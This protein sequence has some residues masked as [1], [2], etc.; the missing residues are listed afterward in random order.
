MLRYPPVTDVSTDL[1]DRPVLV[2]AATAS[3]A[4]PAMLESVDAAF[5]NARTRRYQLDAQT[6]FGLVAD[7]VKA[8]GWDIVQTRQPPEALSEGQ[9]NAVVTTLAGWRDEVAIRVR[10]DV[11]GTV[12]DMRSA[13][14]SGHHHDLG[15]NGLRIEEFLVALDNEVI[16][17]MRDTPQPA[18]ADEANPDDAPETDAPASGG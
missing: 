2:S 12:V 16:L 4:A 17:L 11:E 8:Y 14:L 3:P 5:P 15:A 9:I 6:L 7:L 10:S 13:S 1:V 18:S